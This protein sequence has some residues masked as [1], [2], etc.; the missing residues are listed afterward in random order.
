MKKLVFL[1]WPFWSTF[2][3]INAESSMESFDQRVNVLEKEVIALKVQT[4][5][6]GI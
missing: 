4:S 1:I 2:N 6:L 5:A 3:N